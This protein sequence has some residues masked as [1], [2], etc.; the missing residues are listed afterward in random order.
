[1]VL[2]L[3]FLSFCFFEVFWVIYY[4]SIN[5]YKIIWIHDKQGYGCPKKCDLAT[6]LWVA[7]VTKV[8]MGGS[9]WKGG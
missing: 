2:M 6:L 8:N 1:M 3:M 5:N 4:F 7:R 9:P